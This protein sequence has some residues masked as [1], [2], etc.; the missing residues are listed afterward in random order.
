MEEQQ[1]SRRKVFSGLFW[2]YLETICAQAVTFVVTII[3]AR[4]LS[5][6]DYGIIA[7]VMVFVNVANVFVT[8]SF[9][10]ALIQKNDADDLDYQTMF[11]FNI[12]V[13]FLL[14]A[15][16]FV[17]APT[18]ANYY[19]IPLLSPVLRVL[20][21]KIPLSAYN[22]IQLA[23]V[24]HDLNFKKSF[25]STFGSTILSGAIGIVMAYTGYGIWALVVQV[26]SNILFNTVFLMTIV[27]WLP[28][29][30][31]SFIRLLPLINYGW[32]LLATGFMFTGY[33][34]LCKLIIGKRYSADDLGYYDK[35]TQFPHFIAS[36][37]DSTINRVL[38]PALSNQQDDRI[39]LKE[40]TRRSAKT[41][42][43]IMTPILFGLAITAP[44]IVHL[45]LTD[46]WLPCVPFIQIMCFSWWLQPTQSCSVQGIKA[47]GRSDI[48]LKVE[49][50]AKIC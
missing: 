15:V 49:I 39:R 45:L 48:Y 5:P 31:F 14:F 6:A 43:Y 23:K 19:D 22:S 50:I 41:S 37:V 17:I 2:V 30:Q 25:M 16:L 18:V 35:G 20:A 8:S 46:K 36:N 33:S 47:I 4:L 29:L 32:K 27:K 12:V 26:I 1:V 40:I 13:S 28:K 9:S 34:E 11:W 10:F 7:L 42:A 44:T 3:L 24:S 38:F 21:L